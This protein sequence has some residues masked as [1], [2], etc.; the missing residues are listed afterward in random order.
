VRL[1]GRRGTRGAVT[2]ELAVALPV[3]LGLTVGLV[4]LL[5][6]ATA[7]V[8]AVDSARE[9]ARAVARGDSESS[10]VSVGQGLAPPGSRIT[11]ARGSG[12]IRVR[13]TGAVSGP[14][15]LFA[16][17]PAARFEAEAIALDE[18]VP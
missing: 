18:A 3:L 14:G 8:R 1:A 12:E 17:L 11:V 7:H 2:V 10:A 4:W 15:G 16:R 6:L 9:V 5:S 13:V